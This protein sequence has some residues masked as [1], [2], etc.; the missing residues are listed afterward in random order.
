M[1]SLPEV[2]LNSNRMP[3]KNWAP[4]WLPAVTGTLV[5]SALMVRLIEAHIPADVFQV[6]LRVA[7]VAAI[8][9]LAST[10]LRQSKFGRRPGVQLALTAVS[11]FLF[12]IGLG[13]AGPYVPDM[14]ALAIATAM[15]VA[16]SVDVTLPRRYVAS[17]IGI[18][19][20]GVSA[21]WIE[22]TLKLN[23]D[24]ITLV[25]WSAILF[26]LATVGYSGFLHMTGRIEAQMERVEAVANAAQR[27]GIAIELRDVT[28]AVLEACRDSFPAT[29]IGGILLFRV[30][31]GRLHSAPV[32]LRGGHVVE[33]S[34]NE[35]ELSLMPGEGLA[36]RTFVDGVARCWSTEKAVAEEHTS[37]SDKTRDQV[38][39]VAG[40][41]RSGVVA[42]LRAPER[43]VIGVLTL[44]SNRE[45]A[46]NDA[47]LVVV[48]GLAEQA[49]LGIERARLYADQR[50]QA[51]TDPLTGLANYRHLESVLVQ[52]LARA[53]R[54]ET[55]MAVIFCDLDG[56]K[57][58]NDRYG[59]AVGDQALRLFAAT[60]NLTLR[61]GD[62]AARYGGDEFVCVLPSTDR[63]QAEVVAARLR[64]QYREILDSDPMLAE[65]ATSVSAGVGVFPEDGRLPEQLLRRADSALLASKYPDEVTAQSV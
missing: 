34:G 56:F 1:T 44:G 64:D 62:V 47:D 10:V 45:E 63:A 12:V 27:V 48:Q 54:A 21:L 24:P 4:R 19:A 22:A 55:S 33:N 6:E 38:R 58:V 37:F 50:T 60:T 51:L 7:G 41:I 25:V 46:W 32:S 14:P 40:V 26:S 3:R 57:A 43:G 49:A 29:D 53:D 52:E 36:G 23:Y 59:H 13:I 65:V 8:Y 17:A 18:A 61:K 9:V 28:E 39:E 11:T 2:S 16:L 20:L 30:E 15:V 5:V 35:G 31:D 42:P